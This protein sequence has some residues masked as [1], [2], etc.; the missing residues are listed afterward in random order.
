MQLIRKIEEFSM[1][2]LPAIQTNVYDG[3]VLRFA[4][5]YTKR[6]NSINPIYFSEEELSHKIKNAEQIYRKRNLKV[7]YK[8]TQQVSPETLD[9]TL[10]KKG[11][12]ADSVTSVQILSLKDNIGEI[13]HKAI[14]YDTLHEKWF[15]DFCKLNNVSEKNQRTLKKMLNN[16][17]PKSCYFL[18]TD[19][20]DETLACGMC[21]LES[22]YI[23][24]FDIV[25][26]EKYR[27]RG[28]GSELIQNILQWG[29][30]NGAKY[31]YLQ[32]ILNNTPALKLYSK[33]GFEEVYK[34]WYRIKE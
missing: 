18:L 30:E 9:K 28:Y 21:V 16:I 19:E 29:K 14:V 32:V 22:D 3:W 11:Y 10:E 1:N 26:T 23:G 6:A 31:A 34:Y 25:T 17:I 4:N 24:L 15:V 7:V 27:N 2:A 20:N 12:I 8:I 5:G 13:R 33:L